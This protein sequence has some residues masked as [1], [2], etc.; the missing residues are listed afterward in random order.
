[1][2]A[3]PPLTDE[4]FAKGYEFDF[5]QALKIL[6]AMH[7]D[8]LTGTFDPVDRLART[9][10][11]RSHPSLAFPTSSIH[12]IGKPGAWDGDTRT[13]PGNLEVPAVT[14]NFFGLTGPNGTLPIDYT[15]LLSRLSFSGVCHQRIIRPSSSRVTV[16]SPTGSAASSA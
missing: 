1:M 15:D 8:Q 16:G 5:F 11:V 3:T 7:E 9:I 2:P 14:I 13:D 6:D 10:Q 12:R 4:L